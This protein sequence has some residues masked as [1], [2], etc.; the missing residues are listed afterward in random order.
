[1]A[2]EHVAGAF[3]DAFD[4]WQKGV[5]GSALE[6]DAVRAHRLRDRQLIVNA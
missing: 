1:M 6:D 3:Q 5:V 2:G 4:A